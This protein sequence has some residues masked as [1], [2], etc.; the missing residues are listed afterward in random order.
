MELPKLVVCGD[1]A[2]G[3]SSLVEVL[4]GIRGLLPQ[5]EGFVTQR[6]LRIQ[7]INSNETKYYFHQQE[8]PTLDELKNLI[9]LVSTVHI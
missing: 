4:V 1:Q 7:L 3:K 6:P 5:G 8:I 9:S 2:S